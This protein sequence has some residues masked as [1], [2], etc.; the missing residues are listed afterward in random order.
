MNFLYPFFSIKVSNFKSMQKNY[1]KIITYKKHMT[2][3]LKIIKFILLLNFQQAKRAHK[4]KFDSIIIAISF[5]GEGVKYEEVQQ[6]QDNLMP[7]F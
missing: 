6:K 1:E 5:K 7:I 2:S 4:L 3:C